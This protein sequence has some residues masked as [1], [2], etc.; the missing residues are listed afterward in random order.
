MFRGQ[1][2]ANASLGMVMRGNSRAEADAKAFQA[3]E[4]VGCA[5]LAGRDAGTL[6]GGER[7]RVAMARA[8]ATGAET[9][10]LDEPDAGVDAENTKQLREVIA[11]I[12]RSGK[13]IV[14]SSHQPDWPTSIASD[15]I[16][17]AYGK[18]EPRG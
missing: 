13:T 12:S 18:L 3:L 15:V 4:T 5:H 11:A 17:I 9:L 10:L 6:S 8:L 16:Q 1:V 14:L 2:I 7:K